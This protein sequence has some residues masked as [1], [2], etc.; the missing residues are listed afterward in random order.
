MME[1]QYDVIG[2]E[3]LIM[4]FA[5]RINK[6]PQTDG[7]AYIRDYCWQSG[8]NAASA[9]VALARLGSDCGMVGTTGSD[10]FG[11]FC[12][13]DMH[14]HG[15]DTSHIKHPPGYRRGPE[16]HRPRRWTHA[17]AVSVLRGMRTGAQRLAFLRAHPARHAPRGADTAHSP[18]RRRHRTDGARGGRCPWRRRARWRR[19]QAPPRPTPRP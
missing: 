4:D 6:L 5:V 12:K 17:P 16:A 10:P 14:R 19:R 15:V 3:N 9:I 18:Y 11:T 1:K 8:G 7:F 13:E 2:V